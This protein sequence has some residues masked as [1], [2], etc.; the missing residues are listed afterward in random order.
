[1]FA[2]S[3]IDCALWDLRGKSWASRCI[4][5]LGGPTRDRSCPPTPA[6][7]ATRWNRTRS[8]RAGEGVRRQGLHR[9]RSGFRAG[10]RCDGREG[11]RKNVELMET[12]RASAGPESDI[13]IDA[14]MSWNVPYTLDMAQRLKPY[15]PRWLEEPVLP[16]KIKQYAEIRAESVVPDQRRRARIHPLGDQGA[17]RRP[18]GRPDAGGY[19]LGRRHQRDASRSA[20]SAP[21]TTSRSCRTAIR[22]RPTCS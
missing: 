15:D 8:S 9:A 18:R 10:V 21:R 12:L 20:R 14:W 19:L 22:C 1:M 7:S 4:V 3:A 17:A 6:C 11:I 2:I 16:D 13:M 5:L